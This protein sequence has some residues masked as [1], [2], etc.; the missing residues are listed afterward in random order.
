MIYDLCM[1]YA[2]RHF[3]VKI[4][5]L[6]MCWKDI[7]ALLFVLGFKEYYNP[8][9]HES[10][11]I[12]ESKR[13]RFIPGGPRR[14]GLMIMACIPCVICAALQPLGQRDQRLPVRGE[15][16]RSGNAHEHDISAAQRVAAEHRLRAVVH[17]QHRS[18]GMTGAGQ[19]AQ[20]PIAQ[21]K[22]LPVVKPLHALRRQ[23]R[24]A[25]RFIQPRHVGQDGPV[26]FMQPYFMKLPCRAVMV[27][28]GVGQQQRHGQIGDGP[29][30]GI[31][32]EHP[33]PQSIMYAR[34]RPV[35]R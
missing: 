27:G 33:V 34:S 35:T 19:H 25:Q 1:V 28:M 23:R 3:A 32:G 7:K 24:S 31:T 30:A 2:W 12:I 17:K 6:D 9:L 11:T 22:C 26:P 18:R 4:T 29:H 21:V 16:Q 8:R 14:A 13:I 15:A 20:L 10:N 5:N